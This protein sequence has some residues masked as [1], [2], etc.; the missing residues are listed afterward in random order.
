TAPA[1]NVETRFRYNPDVQSLPA[2][3]PAVIPLLLMMLPAMLTALAVVREKELGSII[4]LYVTPVTRSEFLVGKQLPYIALAI[5]NFLL[6]ALLAVTLFDVPIKGSFLTLLLAVVIYSIIATGMGLLAST[7]TRSQIAAMFFA[8]IGTLIPAV[9]FSGMIDPVSSLEGVGRFIG[10]IYPT[11]YM[12]TITRGVF[13]KALGLGDLYT[14]FVPLLIAV[15]TIMG[16]SIFL[17]KNQ[18]R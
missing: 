4:N 16:L 14:L 11:S 13:S 9:Q 17:L 15:P 18:E 2:M 8:I 6:M 1:A 12:L 3:V 10:T 5:I 7:L